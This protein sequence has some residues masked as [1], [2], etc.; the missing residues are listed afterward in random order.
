LYLK[1]K[2]DERSD[3]TNT[4]HNTRNIIFKS[5]RKWGRVVRWVIPDFSGTQ[6][7]LSNSNNL[8]PSQSKTVLLYL[9][10]FA[11]KNETHFGLLGKSQNVC[12]ILTV[13]GFP[14]QIFTEVL[15]IKFHR[16][17]S[18]G[19]RVDTC[20]LTDRHDKDH[21]HFTW[22]TQMC[23]KSVALYLCFLYVAS[24]VHSDNFTC[25]LWLQMLLNLWESNK[26]AAE[27]QTDYKI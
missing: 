2:Y 6:C 25:H 13:Y 26:N 1:E 17:S 23:L 11:S 3:W 12:L 21:R 20:I 9:L 24:N 18:V 5:S 7:L 16:Q 8:I 10:N 22:L 27:S 14:W 4:K 15:S 19:R